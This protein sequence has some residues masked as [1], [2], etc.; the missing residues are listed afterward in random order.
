LLHAG[1][2]H[3]SARFAAPV[4]HLWHKE[5]D[6]SRLPDNQ[7]R[8]TELLHSSRTRAQLGL[9]RYLSASTHA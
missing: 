5:H 6:R 2:L 1:V 4:F 3:K 8:L 9:D 7:N